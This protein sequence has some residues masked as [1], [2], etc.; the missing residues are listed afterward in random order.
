M[1]DVRDGKQSELMTGTENTSEHSFR[2]NFVNGKLATVEVSAPGDASL[3]SVRLDLPAEYRFLVEK[4]GQP[5]KSGTEVYQNA[6]GARWECL[7]ANWVMPDD[8]WIIAFELIVGSHNRHVWVVQFL[9]KDSPERHSQA[10]PN[11]YG[12]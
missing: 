5:V 9:S 1:T 11:P 10:K 4:Y 8:T 6:Y 12:H 2:W 3:D 7:K